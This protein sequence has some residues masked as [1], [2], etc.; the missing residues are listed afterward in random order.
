VALNCTANGVL[1]G[2]GLF[3]DI[4]VQP[5]AGDDG[6][7]LGAALWTLHE[8]AP[9]TPRRQMTMPYWGDAATAAEVEDAL[10]GL[11]EGYQVERLGAEDLVARVADQVASGA[12]V[13]WFQ[14]RMEFGPRALGNRSILADPGG[15]HMRAHL[16]EVVKQREEF[17]PFAPAVPA[18]DA[19]RYFEIEPG[20]E[21]MYRHMLFVAQV[22]ADY[23]D[24]LPA[25][26]HV[27]GSARVQVV[28][29]GSAPLFWRLLRR[30]GAVRG[31]PV[32]LNTSFN[33]RGQP[34]VRTAAEAVG[35]Y[36]RSRI[37]TLAIGDFLVT[38]RDPLREQVARVWREFLAV[39]GPADA[40]HFFDLGGHSALA[41][42]VAMRLR[43]LTDAELPLDILFEHPQFGDL[44]AALGTEADGPR[45]IGGHE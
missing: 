43:E 24:R 29:R 21:R 27:D 7:A 26:T 2:S 36:A 45:G 4:F 8:R 37:D 6:S 32:L 42:E 33:L 1:A 31:L 17:R 39:D 41:V 44:V 25:V 12:V 40:D 9:A 10:A 11:G 38:R 30:F 14:G 5:A 20:R 22:R 34:I 3:S 15:A 16:N 18:E 28:Q 35:T 23:R 13:A 19:A